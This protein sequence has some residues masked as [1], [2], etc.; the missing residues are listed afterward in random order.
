M[1]RK[2]HYRN[3]LSGINSFD[4]QPSKMKLILERLTFFKFIF[5]SIFSEFSSF[6]SSFSRCFPFTSSAFTLFSFSSTSLVE[7][8]K[9][10]CPSLK[11]WWVL[12]EKVQ[13]LSLFYHK[14]YILILFMFN[15]LKWNV[16]YL[17]KMRFWLSSFYRFLL[18][19]Q[20]W[21]KRAQRN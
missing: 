8:D 4:V 13:N 3:R 12:F 20:K 1:V 5:S 15:H 10:T 6:F 19:G 14:I 21:S 2:K 18:D 7:F 11:L 17:P 9:S 16:P